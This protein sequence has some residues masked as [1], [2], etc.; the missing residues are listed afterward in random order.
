[1]QLV[2]DIDSDLQDPSKQST[3]P[4]QDHLKEKKET[5]SWHSCNKVFTRKYLIKKIGEDYIIAPM[6]LH[7]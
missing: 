5:T 7:S 2:Y 3:L 6:K 4:Q 1:M